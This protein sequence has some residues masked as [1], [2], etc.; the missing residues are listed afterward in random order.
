[1]AEQVKYYNHRGALIKR[2]I[3]K[4]DKIRLEIE[5]LLTTITEYQEQVLKLEKELEVVLDQE[6]TRSA[7]M[8]SK[9]VIE[10]IENNTG[11]SIDMS[12]IKRWSDKGYLGDVF[13]ERKMFWALNV[14]S[15]KQRNL[16]LQE[17]V[18]DFLYSRG[19]ISPKFAILD[20]VTLSDMPEDDVGTIIRNCLSISGFAYT[21]QF[22]DS[23]EI[24]ENVPEYKIQR[25][26]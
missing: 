21:V 23:M 2:C 17:T 12:T 11:R 26:N 4:S 24:V 8:S 6:S 14:G 19:F 5:H 13:D 1:L 22:E 9:E 20:E 7:Y 16:Y 25:V 10:L 3:V 15:G 18:I